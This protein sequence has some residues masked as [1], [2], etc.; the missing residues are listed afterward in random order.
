MAKSV[1]ANSGLEGSRREKL[2]F[3]KLRLINLTDSFLNRFPFVYL[4]IVGL[5]GSMLI[6][7]SIDLL[8]NRIG[9]LNAVRAIGPIS[10]ISGLTWFV[11][12]YIRFSRVVHRQERER[13]NRR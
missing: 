13:E 4:V 9:G 6:V 11:T 8:A 5:L 10:V 1:F 2:M 7:L 12:R 3:L